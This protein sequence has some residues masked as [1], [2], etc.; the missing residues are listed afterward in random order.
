[1]D[2]MELMKAPCPLQVDPIEMFDVDSPEAMPDTPGPH[3]TKKDVEVQDIHRIS[4][5]T[6]SLSPTK[7][8]DDEELGGTKVEQRKGEVTPPKDEADPSKKRKITPSRPSSRKKTKA[9]QTMLKNTLT[10]DDFDF[11]I[12]ALNDVSLELVKKQEAKQEELFHRIM[13]EFKEE[14]QALQSS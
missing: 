10:L 14:Q 7:G 2:I 13:G 4:T 5:K 6:A 3:K 1:M 8:G 12:V 9:T 11:L